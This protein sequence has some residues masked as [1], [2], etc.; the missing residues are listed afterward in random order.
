MLI[1]LKIK[2]KQKPDQVWD[3]I[4]H[5][6]NYTQDRELF[7]KYKKIFPTNDKNYSTKKFR[8]LHFLTSDKKSLIH[9][10]VG[11]KEI[12]E[13]DWKHYWTTHK[14]KQIWDIEELTLE[15]IILPKSKEGN[16]DFNQWREF[17]SIKR[18]ESDKS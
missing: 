5:F 8:A 15:E 10:Y 13:L 1:V 3:S 11:N 7:K 9:V 14:E 4:S 16:L 12:W 17:E 18:N 2:A 6:L